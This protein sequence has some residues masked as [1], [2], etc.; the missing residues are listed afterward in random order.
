MNGTSARHFRNG[1]GKV[2]YK[3]LNTLS[4]FTQRNN[5]D[6]VVK[7]RFTEYQ[8]LTPFALSRPVLSLSKHRRAFRTYSRPSQFPNRAFTLKT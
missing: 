5:I 7:S 3:L 1:T 2:T 4:N 6:E 8:S